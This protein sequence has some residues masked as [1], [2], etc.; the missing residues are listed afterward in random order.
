MK[1]A[2]EFSKNASFWLVFGY[3]FVT[4]GITV[5]HKVTNLF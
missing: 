2:I 1:K 5:W 4:L 3:G